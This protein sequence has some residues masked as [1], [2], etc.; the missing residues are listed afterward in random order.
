MYI[1][2]KVDRKDSNRIDELYRDDIVSRQSIIKREAIS[3]DIKE[4]NIYVLVEGSNEG[5]ERAKQIA[6]KF[7]TILPQKEADNI[8]KKI[9]AQD[10][11][12]LEGMGSIFG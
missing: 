8:Y 6:E 10:E 11:S 1:I 12:S 5:I 9:K 4:D 7:A 2:I 3:L